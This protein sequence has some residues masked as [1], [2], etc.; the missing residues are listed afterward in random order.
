MTRA[1]FA[2]FMVQYAEAEGIELESSDAT[3]SDVAESDWFASA[4]DKVAGAVWY[5][6]IQI[7]RFARNSM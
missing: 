4:V 5:R 6:G 7:K 3:F 2:A 1:E